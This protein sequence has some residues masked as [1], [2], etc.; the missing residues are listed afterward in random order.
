MFTIC[1]NLQMATHTIC[2]T[3]PIALSEKDTIL[4]CNRIHVT[5]LNITHLR[6][7]HVLRVTA[8][9]ATI[10]THLL[11]KPTLGTL[12]PVWL[13]NLYIEMERWWSVPSYTFQML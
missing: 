2:E 13:R 4:T 6:A 5:W 3:V 9:Y 11:C 12:E 1:V 7:Q 8:T 10:L